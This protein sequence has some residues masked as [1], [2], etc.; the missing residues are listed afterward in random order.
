MTRCRAVVCICGSL[1][2]CSALWALWLSFDNPYPIARPYNLAWDVV[3][4]S[5]Q[6][7]GLDVARSPDL[8]SGRM[9]SQ[10]SLWTFQR[11][12]RTFAAM[13]AIQLPLLWILLI[14]V[15]AIA[16]KIG[17]PF[18]GALAPWLCLFSPASIGLA[19]IPADHVAVQALPAASLAILIWSDHHGRRPLSL[20]CAAPMAL[21]MHLCLSSIDLVTL[22]CYAAAGSGYLLSLAIRV[23]RARRTP[24]LGERLLAL[25]WATIGLS[26]SLILSYWL[27]P[28][29]LFD[30]ILSETA[31]QSYSGIL[32]RPGGLLIYPLIWARLQV[33]PVL[34]ATTLAAVALILARRKVSGSLIALGWL[35]G[36]MLALGLI[37]K[38][39]DYYLVPALPGGYV[40]AAVGLSYLSRGFTRSAATLTVCLAAAIFWMSMF[41]GW[42]QP[43]P[44]KASDILQNDADQYLISPITPNENEQLAQW[45]LDRCPPQEG[46]P[47]IISAEYLPNIPF[48]AWH[49]SNEI[50]P[51]FIHFA[52][53]PGTKHS[54][55]LIKTSIARDGPPEL[56]RVLADF[57]GQARQ[58]DNFD[59]DVNRRL[60][61]IER[62]ATAFDPVG[63]YGDWLLFKRESR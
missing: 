25:S 5:L 6:R 45:L 30:Y 22:A 16:W 32:E 33:G 36:P 50:H 47:Y 40:L 23:Q 28:V 8:A 29:I 39:N 62:Q 43:N 34:A 58:L 1:I 55:L 56:L 54:C 35:L 44:V 38:R 11:L 2:L 4:S 31:N 41:L 12:G 51:G 59:S 9:L 19:V 61:I 53:D 37:S 49:A 63:T 3:S 52:P 7:Q 27:V 17:G 20:L 46:Q 15:A 14:S 42:H 48:F 26:L 10:S 18:A 13:N 21:L 24:L 57:R 60:G